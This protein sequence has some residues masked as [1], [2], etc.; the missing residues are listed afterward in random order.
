MLDFYKLVFLLGSG[1]VLGLKH[2]LDADHIAAVSTMVTQTKS[3]KKSAVAGLLWGLG[4]TLA[5][6]AAGAVVLFAKKSIPTMLTLVFEFA[7]GL[8]LVILG[9]DLFR[10]VL[11]KPAQNFTK[12]EHFQE[13]HPAQSKRSLYVG[14][15]H[16]LAGSS[17]L[18]LLALATIPSTSLG[19]LFIGIFGAGSIIGMLGVSMLIGLPLIYT[20]RFAAA[21]VTVK[22][23][24]S[25]VSLAIG[26]FTM[27]EI[28]IVKGLLA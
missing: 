3:M 26:G 10:K 5:L 20:K 27:Y 16:G 17:A 28:G 25:A 23:L 15:L 22:I 8:V 6:L 13:H 9:L 4:H 11:Q 19:F 21:E 14:L 1:L 24:A 7:V 18:M 12:Q 2:A